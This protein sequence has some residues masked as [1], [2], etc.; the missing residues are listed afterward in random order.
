[1]MPASAS[2]I[3]EAPVTTAAAVAD[4]LLVEA[5]QRGELLTNLKLQKLLYYAQAWYLALYGRPL[6][7]EDFEAWVH[8]PVLRSQYLRFKP[9]PGWASITAPV[10]RPSL[11]EA[12]EKFLDEILDIFGIESSIAL[13]MMTHRERPWLEA[14]DGLPAG[15]PSS[16]RI[17]KRTMMEFYRSMQAK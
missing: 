14:R 13:E 9:E 4:Y 11:P 8:G 15:E 16:A 17:S 6:F 12:I 2:E 7:A 10:E 3:E 1:M 5:R